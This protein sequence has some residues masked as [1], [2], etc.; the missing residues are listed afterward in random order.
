VTVETSSFNVSS[1][2]SSMG[3]TNVVL[4][5]GSLVGDFFGL[6]LFFLDFDFSVSFAVLLLRSWSVSSLLPPPDI[7]FR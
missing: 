3:V 7:A 1:I 5:D 4:N 2:T 6:F